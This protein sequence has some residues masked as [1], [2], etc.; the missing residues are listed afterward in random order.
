MSKI[1][2]KKMK[3]GKTHPWKAHGGTSKQHAEERNQSF[4]VVNFNST[5]GVKR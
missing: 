5:M 2:P 3:N 1:K 4:V